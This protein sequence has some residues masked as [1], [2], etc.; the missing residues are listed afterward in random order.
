MMAKM[1][2]TLEEAKAALNKNEEEIKQYAREG[3][4]REFRDGPRLM[5]KADQVEQLKGELGGADQVDL[6]VSDSGGLIGLVDT[7]GASGT[8]ITL[9]DT[10]H[11]GQAAGAAKK[12]DTALAAD[13]GLSGSAAGMPS[14]RAGSGSGLASSGS[15]LMSSGSG[16][17]SSGSGLAPA[18]SGSGLSSG[19]GSKSGINVLGTEEVGVDPSAQTAITSGVREQ[20]DLAS[21]GSGSGLLDLSR[22][23]DDTSLGAVLDEIN[24][25]ASSRTR[26]AA[27][28]IHDSAMELD[29]PTGGVVR[30]APPMYVEA[31]D[32]SALGFGLACLAA[33]IV[34]L[35]GMYAVLAGAMG[36]NLDLIKWFDGRGWWFPAACG[37]G[38]VAVLFIIGML[39]GKSRTA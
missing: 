26:A 23:S 27:V 36:A 33:A 20:I 11:G 16:L 31:P 24:P 34:V 9:S 22:E 12:E 38:A 15:G 28:E 14:P 30:S 29:E 8:S 25:N 17:M 35:V 13:L 1:F 2:Y 32:A 7:T 6:G 10:E 39:A 5:F 19:H 18:G 37:F 21:V 4:L 3:R